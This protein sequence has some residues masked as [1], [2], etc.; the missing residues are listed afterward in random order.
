MT[1]TLISLPLAAL[2]LAA[3]THEPVAPAPAPVVLA[4]S[5]VVTAPPAG[6]V[7]V[8]PQTMTLPGQVVVV[9]A[10]APLRAGFGRIESIMAATGASA[11]GTAA[12]DETR[13]FAVRMEDGTMQF[14]DARAPNLGIG[15]RV[16]ITRDGYIRSPV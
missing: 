13:R 8:V 11:G 12:A 6:T 7:Q 3:C 4:P 9:P 15:H 14:L 5:T 2:A 10:P 1:K 16:E